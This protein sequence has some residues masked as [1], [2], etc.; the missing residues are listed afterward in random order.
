MKLHNASTSIFIPDGEPE[1]EALSRVSH[2]GIGAHQDDLEFMAFHGI[3]NCFARDDRWFGG[4]T[5]SNGTGSSRSGPYAGFCDARMMAIRRQEPNTA[6]AAIEAGAD[7]VA[8]IRRM[9]GG[10]MSGISGR[11]SEPPNT[12]RTPKGRGWRGGSA[13][14]QGAGFRGSATCSFFRV[15]GGFRWLGIFFVRMI[16]WVFADNQGGPESHPPCLFEEPGIRWIRVI[17]DAF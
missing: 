10:M 15:S 1:G 9:R 13:F 3:L 5:C 16:V 11:V 6:A 12:R 8:K 7:G 2:L 17:R 14:S 4:V